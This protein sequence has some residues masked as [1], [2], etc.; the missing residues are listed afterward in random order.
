MRI[1]F[2]A[3]LLAGICFASGIK[4]AGAEDVYV[5]L[6][7]LNDLQP[8][9][10]G[11]S[12]SQPLFPIVEKSSL[13]IVKDNP[14]PAPKPKKAKKI[15]KAKKVA[16]PQPVA[17]PVVDTPK[18]VEPTTAKVVEQVPAK[19]AEPT[20]A[21]QPAPQAQP[22]AEAAIPLPAKPEVPAP[23]L[24]PAGSEAKPNALMDSI[25]RS[26]D[27]A[28]KVMDD[29][30]ASLSQ[31]QQPSA[32]A[33]E[34][35][36]APQNPQLNQ[37]APVSQPTVSQIETNDVEEGL[38]LEPN[39][40]TPA[41]SGVYAPEVAPVVAAPSSSDTSNTAAPA[42]APTAN[43]APNALSFAPEEDELSANQQQQLDTILSGFV[44]P[45][46]NKIAITSYNV[47]G[48]DDVFRRKRISLNRATG[49]RSYFLNKGY[50]NFSIKI[51]NIPS[52]DP[53]A[54]TVDIVELQ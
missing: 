24:N 17:K 13:S 4:V 1:K 46:K 37:P 12:A 23:S 30:N 35:A 2:T 52:G 49:V 34:G 27:R 48:G 47:E 14:A 45:N 26:Q 51:V 21:P 3:L 28:Q 25:Q 36:A 22:V 44:N 19:V 40:Q 10:V 32:P 38:G 41:N 9:Y 33:I 42:A 53:R 18:A 7:V 11:Q 15:K 54:D 31:P 16:K 39:P 50:K 8:G 29:A 5:D 20:V 43:A 6:S